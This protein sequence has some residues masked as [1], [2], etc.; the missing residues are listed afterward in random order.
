M[1]KFIVSNSKPTGSKVAGIGVYR[2]KKIVR[3]SEIVEKINSSDEW[4]RERS[5]IIERRY[6]D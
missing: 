2:P 6:A 1:V 3:N 5:G 4:I